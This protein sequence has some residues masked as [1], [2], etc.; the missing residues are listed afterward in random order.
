MVRTEYRRMWRET[1]LVVLP[2]YYKL[3]ILNCTELQVYLLFYARVI[4]ELS[5]QGK[6]ICCGCSRAKCYEDY[7]D[8]RWG[9]E[10]EDR[11]NC[12]LRSFR[13]CTSSKY[14]NGYQIMEDDMGCACGAGGKI[15]TFIRNFSRKTCG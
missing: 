8:L 11:G 9:K 2:P 6:K 1:Y 3:T 5:P 13:V 7:L 4:L 10:E 14:F 12:I 15:V